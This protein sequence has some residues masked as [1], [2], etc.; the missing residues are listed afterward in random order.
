MENNEGVLLR[1]AQ[2][3][4]CSGLLSGSAKNLY[5]HEEY[6]ALTCTKEDG[7]FYCPECYTDAVLRK[8]SEKRDHFA[9]KSR[10][11]PVIGPEESELH[12]QCKT[13]ICNLFSQRYP[14]GKWAVERSIPENKSQN[15]PE[16]RP[17][18]SGRIGESRVAI[19]V[20]ASSL[21]ISKIVKRAESYSKRDIALLWI[22]PL[23][24]PLGNE[25]F[26][27]RL[28]E[29]YLHSIYFGR[30][31]YWWAGQGLTIKPVHYA[32]AVR[33]VEYREWFAEGG[34]HMEGGGYDAKY[35]I[36]KEP[37]YGRDCNVADDFYEALREQFIPD[38]ERKAVPAC[39]IWKD[40]L[41]PWWE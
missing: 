8:C 30:T 41:E 18:I 6:D 31:Y 24:Q 5:S 29:R 9:H 15:I 33:H 17:D 25:S 40:I 32:A 38:N 23:L 39:K 22:V 37:N 14:D 12:Y 7:P 11:T 1:D 4:G 19:E 13:E 34:E 2:E 36:V 26:R 21:T 3:V 27:P 10:L 35:K 28:Y 16:L 20:Q